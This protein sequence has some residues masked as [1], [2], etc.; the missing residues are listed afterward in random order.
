MDI[1][2]LAA[3]IEALEPRT[4][5]IVLRYLDYLLQVQEKEQGLSETSAK[6]D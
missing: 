6:G 3:Q 4:K 2:N 1:R 5:E